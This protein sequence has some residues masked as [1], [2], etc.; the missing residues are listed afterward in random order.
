MIKTI[1][2]KLHNKEIFNQNLFEVSANKSRKNPP[3][4]IGF[5]FPSYDFSLFENLIKHNFKTKTQEHID[6]DK[7]EQTKELQLE[8]EKKIFHCSKIF[9]N[10][11]NDRE[12]IIPGNGLIQFQ[13]TTLS[14]IKLLNFFNNQTSGFITTFEVKF[15]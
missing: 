3:F 8:I 10:C 12:F 4:Q 15:G 7:E 1:I 6:K 11:S 2:Q 5:S 13:S 14:Y 9:V